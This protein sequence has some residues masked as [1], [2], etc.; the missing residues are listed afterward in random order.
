MS[1][2]KYP[3]NE[4]VC[5][6]YYDIA[7]KLKYIVTTKVYSSDLYFLYESVDDE[8]KKLGKA[9]TPTELEIKFDIDNKI[10]N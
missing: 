6:S 3:K 9:K 5:T 7:H 8:F 2:L 4:I 10:K 1:K